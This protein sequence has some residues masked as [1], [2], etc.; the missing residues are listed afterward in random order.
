MPAIMKDA[1][2][3]IVDDF[4]RE[5]KE[6][7]RSTSKPKMVVINFRDEME[8]GFERPKVSIPIDILRYRKNNGRISSD[9]L[10]YEWN[11][12]LLNERDKL[13]QDIIREF[14]ENK[15]PEKTDILKKTIIHRGQQEHAIIT[16]DGFLVNGNRRKMVLEMLQHEFPNEDKYRYMDVVILPGKDEGEGGPPTLLEIEQIENRYQLQKDGRSEYYGF[17]LALSIK[18]K[19][20]VGFTLKAQLLD[21]PRHANATK[22]Q[23]E[24]A[25]R[26]HKMDYL[27]PL[28]CIDRYL[29]QFGREGLYRT[30]STGISDPE[31]RWQA[32]K[33]YSNT[34]GRIFRNPKKLIDLGIDEDE[35][36]E[37]EEA[38]F[39]I[40]RLRTVPNMPKVHTIMR[41]IS[42]YCRTPEGK[43]HIKMISA[44]VDP[45]LPVE[46]CTDDSG[47]RLTIQEIDAKWAA[48]NKE[49]IT[50]HVKIA[51]RSH[52]SQKEKETPLHLLE[53]AYKKLMHEDMDLQAIDISDFDK[54]REWVVKI[55]DRADDL[56][57][58]IYKFKK[59]LKNLTNKKS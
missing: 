13:S 44:T 32:F 14:L 8:I 21:D 53:A 10:D 37:I 5:I 57:G 47:K 9:V 59:E 51:S 1:A 49:M 52:E 33:D 35:I 41:N 28:G 42:K 12:G 15:D 3:E 31:G 39:D 56:E 2:R 54:A 11:I 29:T 20:G 22:K 34:Y 19:I 26:E 4:A 18:R 58:D 30:I 16:C 25:V 50:Y 55:K 24:K 46:E 17:D 7:L 48:K 45:I 23:I 40:I 27:Q 43:K 6:K 36:G 38:A